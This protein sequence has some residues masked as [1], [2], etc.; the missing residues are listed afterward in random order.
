MPTITMP[1]TFDQISEIRTVN[2]VMIALD[3]IRVLRA[4]CLDETLTPKDM[5]DICWLLDWAY[6]RL[7]NCDISGAV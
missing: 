2:D 4:K 3:R 6:N 7:L 5:D 1:Q